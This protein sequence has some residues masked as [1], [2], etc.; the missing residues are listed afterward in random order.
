[1]TKQECAIVMAYTGICMLHGDDFQI[2][3]EYVE[4][5]VERPVFTHEFAFQMFTDY[6]KEKAEPDFIKLCEEAT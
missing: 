5:V 1:M 3:H 4:K 2:F 6:L